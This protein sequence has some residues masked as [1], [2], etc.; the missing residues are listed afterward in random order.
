MKKCNLLIIFF[1]TSFLFGKLYSQKVCILGTGYVGLVTGV[2]LASIGN[3]VCCADVL[4][5]KIEQ[6]CNGK[7]PIYEPGLDELMRGPVAAGL[8]TFSTNIEVAIKQSDIIFVAVGTPMTENG[9]ADLKVLEGAFDTIAKNIVNYKII[10]VKST[11]PVGTC[12]RMQQML[13]NRGIKRDLFDIVSNPEFLREGS[14]V[15]DFLQPDRIVIGG[16]SEAVAIVK[17]LYK[18]ILDKGCFCLTTT[19]E[20]SELI[21][22]ASNA[23][24]ASRIVFINEVARLCN[25]VSANVQDVAIGMGLD[26]RIG[27]DFLKPG[28]G[29]G[30][31]CFPKDTKALT[32]IMKVYDVEAQ[33]IE[34]IFKSNAV[35]KQKIL[36]AISSLLE[37]NLSGKNIALL[38][39]TF[40]ANTDDIRDSF[41][42]DAIK[43]LTKHDATVCVYDPQGMSNTK[44]IF[45]QIIYCDSAMRAINNADLIIVAT[46]WEEFRKLD[47][48]ECA[49]KCRTKILVD[50]RNLFNPIELQKNGFKYYNLGFLGVYS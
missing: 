45:P 4:P 32:Q 14:A 1:I 3:K 20:S 15:H 17:D 30:G 36:D 7:M 42:L 26:Q 46:E 39:L 6:L 16:S 8:L 28:P 43:Y 38:G 22:Y 10:C 9:C 5:E 11:V 40:K 44:K 50:L 48:A 12:R 24:L 29:F 27:K 18:S 49:Q 13:L 21:K 25:K 33:L 31:S 35:H 34:S 23:M 2:G 37:N 47:L 19:L 41:S